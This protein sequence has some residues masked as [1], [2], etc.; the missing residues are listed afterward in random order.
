MNDAPRSVQVGDVVGFRYLMKDEN[1][2]VL[3]ASTEL[4]H[5]VHGD[6]HSLPH[7]VEEEMK[8]R[9]CGETFTTTVSRIETMRRL[10]LP[11]DRFPK[12]FALEPGTRIDLRAPDGDGFAVW[13]DGSESKTLALGL[14][15]PI[16]GK[17]IRFQISIISI[18]VAPL[19]ASSEP[20]PGVESE[21]ETE[22]IDLRDR[23][24]S[25]FSKES[26]PGG[27]FDALVDEDFSLAHRVGALRGQHA[28]L[29]E[30]LDSIIAQVR[31]KGDAY[32]YR[33]A[34]VG[35]VRSVARHEE[36]STDMF[37]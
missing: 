9:V 21:L 31:E 17:S 18:R 24:A 22:L 14:D 37:V 29:L 28:M 23:L 4:V 11:E 19:D 12:A 30:H 15:R 26:A 33:P 1:D 10:L 34:L 7:G 8:G 32:D 25:K 13:V 2:V 16:V 35:L 6:H 27:L 36:A 5:C 20:T 3:A